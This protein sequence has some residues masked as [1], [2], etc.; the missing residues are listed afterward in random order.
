MAMKLIQF[1]VPEEDAEIIKE[2]A[3]RKKMSQAEW[4]RWVAV[5]NAKSQTESRASST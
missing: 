1:R 3:W 5:A 4:L 2:A